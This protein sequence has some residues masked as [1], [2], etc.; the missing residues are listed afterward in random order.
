MATCSIR[1]AFGMNAGRSIVEGFE[2]FFVK[3]ANE[4][5]QIFDQEKVVNT[6]I[7]MGASRKIE[8]TIAHE[9]N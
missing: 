5:K 1:K 7:R 8:D 2:C 9:A 4:T 6:C 3:K